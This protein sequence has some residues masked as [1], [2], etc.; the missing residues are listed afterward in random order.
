MFTLKFRDDMDNDLKYKV[1][2]NIINELNIIP[3][4]HRDFNA[5]SFNTDIGIKKDILK[6]AK[7]WLY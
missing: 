7:G 2:T 5:L 6:V 3:V 1:R 4:T